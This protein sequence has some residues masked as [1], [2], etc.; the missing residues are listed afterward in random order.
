MTILQRNPACKLKKTRNL[1]TKY[2]WGG[3]QEWDVATPSPQ[4]MV[5][6]RGGAIHNAGFQ[7]ILQAD[8]YS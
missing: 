3:G 8:M 4:A 7:V 1:F 2:G 6:E 5:P